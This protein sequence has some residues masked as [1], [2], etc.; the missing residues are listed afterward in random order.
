MNEWM[1]YNEKLLNIHENADEYSEFYEYI[2]STV[3]EIHRNWV[4]DSNVQNMLVTESEY[5]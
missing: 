5:M 4:K 3:E 2:D 1:L